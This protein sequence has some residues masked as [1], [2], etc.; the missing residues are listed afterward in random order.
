MQSPH[1]EFID[2]W[3]KILEG[4]EIQH[5]ELK[6]VRKIKLNLPKRK[7]YIVNIETMW[8]QGLDEDEIKKLIVQAFEEHGENIRSVEFV[9]DIPAL[10]SLIQP[11]TDAILNKL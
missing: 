5:V 6:Y 2:K 4:V 9:L 7:K 3:E 8:E 1:H 10:S 11:E